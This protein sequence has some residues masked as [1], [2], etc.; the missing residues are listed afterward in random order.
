MV[1]G[2][3]PRY[4]GPFTIRVRNLGVANEYRIVHN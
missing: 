1:C 4:T 3:T 2:W